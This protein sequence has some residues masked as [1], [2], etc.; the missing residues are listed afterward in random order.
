M[1]AAS[2]DISIHTS[3]NNPFMIYRIVDFGLT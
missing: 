3:E 2:A 1:F